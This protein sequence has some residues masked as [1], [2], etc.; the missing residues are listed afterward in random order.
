M[1]HYCVNKILLLV[2][3][4]KQA[5]KFKNLRDIKIYVN[6]TVSFIFVF[7]ELSQF[8]LLSKFLYNIPTYP[9]CV[10]LSVCLVMVD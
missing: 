9:M 2:D 10:K 4:V 3:I 6:I 7:S 1:V 5:N 8:Q